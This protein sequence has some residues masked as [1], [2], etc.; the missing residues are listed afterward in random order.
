MVDLN[1]NVTLKSLR[2][3]IRNFMV[4]LKVVYF[5]LVKATI[6]VCKYLLTVLSENTRPTFIDFVQVLLWLI[7]NRYCKSSH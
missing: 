1:L 5:C 6:P 3:S 7:L 2:F 4:D